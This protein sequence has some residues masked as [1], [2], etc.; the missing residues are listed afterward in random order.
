VGEPR[1][2]RHHI[3][4][5]L[6]RVRFG[7]SG[8]ARRGQVRRDQCP[9][10]RRPPRR[11]RGIARPQQVG[12]PIGGGDLQSLPASAP[13]CLSGPCVVRKPRSGRSGVGEPGAIAHYG[14]GPHRSRRPV[15]DARCARRRAKRQGQRLPAHAAPMTSTSSAGF[16]VAVDRRR[17]WAREAQAL[18][19]AGRGPASRPIGCMS[20]GQCCWVKAWPP[21]R[22]QPS[23][24][25]PPASATL[26]RQARALRP[27]RPHGSATVKAGQPAHFGS[28]LRSPPRPAGRAEAMLASAGHRLGAFAARAKYLGTYSGRP[29]PE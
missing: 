2:S 22:Q 6:R 13:L 19:R 12:E 26:C 4:H 8:R 20:P 16:A 15:D 25:Q 5:L 14:Q 11:W 24:D 28:P 29:A 17:S 10:P 27:W 1:P 3:Q 9:P 23:V 21:S 7:A 18:S